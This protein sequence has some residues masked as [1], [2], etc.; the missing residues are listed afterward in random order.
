MST[1][2]GTLALVVQPGATE[3]DFAQGF[4]NSFEMVLEKMTPS[5]WGQE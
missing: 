3:T 2:I 5:G 1:V 4:H